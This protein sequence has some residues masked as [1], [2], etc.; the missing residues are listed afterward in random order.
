MASRVFRVAT[1]ASMLALTQ[2]KQTVALLEKANPAY[3]FELVTVRTSGDA[4]TGTP[5]AGFGGVGV[6][7]KEL[8]TALR[9]NRADLAIHS[10]KDVPSSVADGMTIAS[11]PSRVDPSD[12]VMTVG[13]LSLY[14]L[15]PGARV[16][17]GSPRRIMQ[18]KAIRPDLQC[19]GIRGNLDTRIRK[20]NQGDFDAI[21]LAAAGMIRL[22]IDYPK[23]GVMP[24]SQCVP[25]CG[26]GAL[27]IE[28]RA[29]DA[30]TI[31]VVRKIN[32]D[33]TEREASAERAFMKQTGAGCAV[34]VAGFAKI[35]QSTL[36]IRAVAGDLT[37]GKI[38]SAEHYGPAHDFTQIGIACA[39]EILARCAEH[40]INL[41][42]EPSA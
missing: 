26:Q 20:L 33:T 2:T 36:A 35:S 9:E 37:T 11:F 16:G 41:T 30:E 19:T 18:L 28:C 42:L 7:V 6:F 38:V 13:G 17:T 3:A 25:A 21:I 31:S 10:L 14:Q 1:R 29:D 27:G 15:A 39:N 24:L 23:P 12:V 5:L 40:G 8:E 22:G 32:D 34:P 4:E